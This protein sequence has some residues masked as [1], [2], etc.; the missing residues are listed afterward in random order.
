MTECIPVAHYTLISI[1]K[2]FNL[3]LQCH[4]AVIS[5]QLLIH[6]FLHLAFPWFI[7]FFFYRNKWRVSYLILLLTMLVDLD[8]L[9]ATPLF[10]P[11]RCSIGFHPLHSYL[12]IIVYLLMLIHHKIRI[13]AIGL[14]MHMATDAIDCLFSTQACQ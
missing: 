3:L 8:H 10:D 13:I 6:F 14:L 9:I 5:M 1:Y 12:A 4:F 11:C 7:A 2:L